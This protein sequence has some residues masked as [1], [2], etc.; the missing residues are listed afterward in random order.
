MATRRPYSNYTKQR[1][2]N[3]WR[4]GKRAPTIATILRSE[5]FS[6]SR[7]GIQKFL[8]RYLEHG[9]IHR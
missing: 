1:A 4:N 2:L 3:L 9:T 7:R 8:K 6:V 5:G